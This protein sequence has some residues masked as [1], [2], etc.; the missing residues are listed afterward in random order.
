MTWDIK[1]EA[2]KIGVTTDTGTY[3]E[4]MASNLR[5]DIVGTQRTVELDL[6]PSFSSEPDKLTR[7]FYEELE[8]ADDVDQLEFSDNQSVTGLRQHLA[9]IPDTDVK[10]S[11]QFEKEVREYATVRI[12]KSDDAITFFFN[13]K[14][15]VDV[16]P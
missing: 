15:L 8:E 3:W 9:S 13:S 14:N 12:D 16:S 7:V 1:P 5:L 11:I 10:V 2:Q 4:L 6:S